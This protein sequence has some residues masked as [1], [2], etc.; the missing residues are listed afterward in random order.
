MNNKKI[1]KTEQA[2]KKSHVSTYFQNYNGFIK[3]GL[4]QEVS[5]STKKEI[6]ILS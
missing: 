5:S 6:A 4:E 1:Y 2:L 3:N